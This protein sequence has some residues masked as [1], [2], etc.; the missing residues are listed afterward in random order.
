MPSFDS[1]PERRR[2]F[3]L[4]WARKQFDPSKRNECLAK[5]GYKQSVIKNQGSKIAKSVNFLIQKEMARQGIGPELL[6]GVH[7]ENLKAMHPAHPESPDTAQ[8]NVALKMAYELFDAF[9]SKKF[10]IDKRE[11]VVNISMDTIQ[12][13]EEATGQ[14]VMDQIPEGSIIDVETEESDGLLEGADEGDTL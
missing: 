1:L 14:K 7:K 3:Y 6:V 9:P 11:L 8:R 2:V 13:I 12:D 10:E 5:A 4:R